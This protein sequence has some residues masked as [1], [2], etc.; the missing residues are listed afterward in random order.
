M[1]P[2]LILLLVGGAG[3]VG[4]GVMWWQQ[5]GQQAHVNRV[6]T[7][8]VRAGQI[9]RLGPV[10]AT[11]LD[12]HPRRTYS[13]GIFGAL[14][15][16]ER[17]I[18]FDGH[19]HHTYNLNLTF[20]RLQR[21]GLTTVP[22]IIGRTMNRRRVLALHYDGPDGWRVATF[23]L[24]A[25]VEFANALGDQTGLPVR[26]SGQAR[27]DYPPA[28]AIRMIQDIYGEWQEDREGEL[29]L[30]P[31]R[32]LF[33]GREPIPLA[34]I[35]RLDIFQQA[36]VNPLSAD[37]LRVEYDTPDG[38]YDFETTGFLVRRADKWAEEIA[39]RAEAPLTI[40]AG[41]KK[42]AE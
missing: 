4:I 29:Y 41:R 27:D 23:L 32:L 24:D 20:D 13:G 12:L 38:D 37:L 31:D 16:V 7:E 26:D 19:R 8:W 28:R 2:E 6:R 33:S 21:I 10:G 22:V 40:H 42:K 9:V 14:G 15:I 36:S 25:P 30:A 34:A 18:M 5:R 17:Q 39:Q 35:R 1:T 11:C 3:V